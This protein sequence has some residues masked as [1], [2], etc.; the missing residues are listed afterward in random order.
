[1]IKRK[2]IQTLFC[3]LLLSSTLFST[4]SFADWTKDE[5]NGKWQ[6]Q[7]EDGTLASSRW[8]DWEGG[9]YYI[10]ADGFM[11]SNQTLEIDG[12]CYGFYG[13]GRVMHT[14]DITDVQIG[15]LNLYSSSETRRTV[16]SRWA[17]Y[18]MELPGNTSFIDYRS[19]AGKKPIYEFLATVP[20]TGNRP[21]SVSSSYFQM[22]G[23]LED[24][25]SVVSSFESDEEFQFLSSS[26]VTLGNEKD[27]QKLSFVYDQDGIYGR[28]VYR[29]C[30]IRKIGDFCHILTFEYESAGAGTVE[31]IV[32]SLLYPRF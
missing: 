2:I 7:L 4:V 25:G 23:S 9:R 16:S 3:S 31:T 12:T 1:M 19:L 21:L 5:E 17:Y 6:Y 32:S 10:G 18:S 30:Y 11:V 8:I 27:Y 29:D 28:P 20:S 24:Y 15:Y 26:P 13:D 22:D 14:S